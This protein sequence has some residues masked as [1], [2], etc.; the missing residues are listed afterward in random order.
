MVSWLQSPSEVILEHNRVKS[1]T[2]M[3]LMHFPRETVY[4]FQDLTLSG[5]VLRVNAEYL[6]SL[7]Y[8]LGSLRGTVTFAGG[9]LYP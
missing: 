3:G 4:T 6:F 5:K 2:V 7:H 8:L 1:A 9:A